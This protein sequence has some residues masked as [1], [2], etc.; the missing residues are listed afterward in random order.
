[1]SKK[2]TIMKHSTLVTEL[3]T[4]EA[5]G[6]QGGRLV[7][8]VNVNVNISP[9]VNVSPT[10]IVGVGGPAINTGQINNSG[11]GD[12]ILAGGPGVVFQ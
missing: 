3:T 5:A 10:I 6:I 1:V 12:N 8:D 7:P 11:G 4:E 9:T 2:S